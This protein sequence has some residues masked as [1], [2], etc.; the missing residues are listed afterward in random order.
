MNT[1][2]LIELCDKYTVEVSFNGFQTHKHNVINATKLL[3]EIHLTSDIPKDE[4][5]LN[6]NKGNFMSN[7][8]EDIFRNIKTQ[9]TFTIAGHEALGC[10]AYIECNKLPWLP[11]QK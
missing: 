1:T 5:I 8:L 3:E 9:G 7:E 4:F 2:K 11:K 6:I 10:D